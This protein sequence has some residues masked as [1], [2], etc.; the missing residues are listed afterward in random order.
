MQASA[1]EPGFI[2]FSDPETTLHS[3]F[4]AFEQK[5]TKNQS[6]LSAET[7]HT[8]RKDRQDQARQYRSASY[9]FP[10]SSRFGDDDCQRSALPH[11]NSRASMSKAALRHN[12]SSMLG[13]ATKVMGTRSPSAMDYK[14]KVPMKNLGDGCAA[15]LHRTF[16]ST[17]H[18]GPKYTFGA[19][20]SRGS[21]LT[22]KKNRDVAPGD[23]D[24]NITAFAGQAL[25]HTKSLPSW[26]FA[27]PVRKANIGQQ[28]PNPRKVNSPPPAKFDLNPALG[29]QVACPKHT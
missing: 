24:V 13:N 15:A 1:S 25:S 11:S 3:T 18:A 10:H 16:V 22:Y 6:P 28:L 20:P 27:A 26:S 21:L 7:L 14:P 4:Q 2:T 17:Q 8:I 29:R 19:T 23:Y 9:S 5:I 12:S